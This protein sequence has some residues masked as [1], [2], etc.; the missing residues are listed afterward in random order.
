MA[1]DNAEAHRVLGLAL[2]ASPQEIKR[3]YRQ[4]AHWCHPDKNPGN[5]VAEETFKRVSEAYALLS[6][7]GSRTVRSSSPAAKGEAERPSPRREPTET[8]S[9]EDPEQHGELGLYY[10]KALREKK[11]ISEE[12]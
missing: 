8:S 5:V 2:G 9:S 10:L 11:L 4:A 12:E 7:K 3:A 6:G 1:M